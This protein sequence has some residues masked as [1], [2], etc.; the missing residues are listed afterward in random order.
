MTPGA[1]PGRPPRHLLSGILRC[2]EC[3]GPL[4][5]VDRYRYGC[6]AHKDRGDSVCS[7]RLRVPRQAA[8]TALLAGIQSALLVEA[9]FIQYQRTMTAAI[10]AS[11]PDPA[12]AERKLAH[13]EQVHGNIMAALRAGIITASTKSEL[14]S[15]ERNVDA[16]KAELIALRNHQPAQMV[17]RMRERWRGIVAG[18]TDR[19][20][21]PAVRQAL[22]ALVGSSVIVRNENGALFA[23]I[24]PSSQ[25]NM[26]AGAR[27]VLYLTEPFRIPLQPASDGE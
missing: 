8:E 18:L 24:A 6:S 19:R 11:A 13:A 1:G 25:I 23:E 12:C 5:I 22:I 14:V 27:S 26:V 15:A 4:V 20:D 21:V 16:A 17:P 10:K 7:S 2:A 9:R 3:G